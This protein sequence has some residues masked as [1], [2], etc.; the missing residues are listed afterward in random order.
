[1]VTM[2]IQRV[3]RAAAWGATQFTSVSKVVRWVRQRGTGGLSTMQYA[4]VE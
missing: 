2:L 4:K 3:L 1:M